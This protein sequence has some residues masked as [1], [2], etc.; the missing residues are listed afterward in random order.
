MREAA[1]Y[2]AFDPNFCVCIGDT[3]T[4]TPCNTKWQVEDI[5][6]EIEITGDGDGDRELYIYAVHGYMISQLHCV[7]FRRI[8]RH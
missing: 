2:V 6:Q 3:I 7:N 1:T 8:N 4:F 5:L